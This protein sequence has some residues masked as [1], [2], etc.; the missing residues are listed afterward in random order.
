MI[1]RCATKAQYAEWRKAAKLCLPPKSS[2]FCTD[3]TAE[4]QHKMK[5]A[6]KCVFPKFKIKKEK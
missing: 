3:C 5:I 2:W 1:Y 6:G 4:Y